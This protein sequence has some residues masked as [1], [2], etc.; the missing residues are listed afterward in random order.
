MPRA[1]GDTLMGRLAIRGASTTLAL[2]LT[3]I[4]AIPPGYAAPASAARLPVASPSATVGVVA[5][6]VKK[7]TGVLRILKS[8]TKDCRRGEKRITW[9]QTGAAGPIGPAGATGPTGATGQALSVRAADGTVIGSLAGML[10]LFAAAVPIFLVLRDG[11]VWYYLN[12]GSLMTSSLY[13]GGA[14]T[15]KFTD[16]GCSG[17]P[18]F[19][20]GVPSIPVNL[21][22]AM[23]GSGRIVT[24]TN[25]GVFA[26]YKIQAQVGTTIAA[27]TQL[28][29]R[30]GAGACMAD[31]GL[32]NSGSLWA[33]TAVT[34]PPSFSGPL[35]V[36]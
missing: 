2:V 22:L 15:V 14:Q 36:G 4:A 17:T 3:S 6:C 30:D 1:I 24:R 33:L 25:A 18:S 32:V 5:G 8:P 31:V 7:R 11:G 23:Q 21:G 10:P 27:P 19:F 35:T 29:A 9:N 34:P 28:Y 20:T 13:T 26:A 12:D 16:N